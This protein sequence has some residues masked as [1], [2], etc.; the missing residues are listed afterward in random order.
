MR[1]IVEANP[2]TLKQFTILRGNERLIFPVDIGHV[3]RDK[4]DGSRVTVGRVGYTVRLPKRDVGFFTSI[5]MAF[6]YTVFIIV[7]TLDFLSKL[8]TFRMPAKLLGGPVMIAQLAGKSAQ[9]GFLALLDFTAFISINLGIL[10]LLPFPVLDGGHVAILFIESLVR[11]KISHRIRMAIQ[12]AGTLVLL[13][14]MLYI[15][16]NDVTRLDFI[17]RLFGSN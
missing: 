14:L 2:D 6:D 1:R 17:A 7:H 4:L 3:D 13:L 15:T 12:Q 10:N 11:R 16:Y 5:K 8:I 9:S